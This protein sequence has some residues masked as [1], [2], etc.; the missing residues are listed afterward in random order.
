MNL[1][2]GGAALVCFFGSLS[3]FTPKVSWKDL[4]VYIRENKQEYLAFSNKFRG[5]YLFFFGCFFLLLFLINLFVTFKVSPVLVFFS[6][7]FLF[8]LAIARIIL[9]IKWQKF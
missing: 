5:R 7:L 1:V 8:L 6:F 2:L 4:T 3:F 9:E